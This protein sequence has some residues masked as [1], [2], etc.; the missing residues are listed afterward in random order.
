MF[1]FTIYRV[2]QKGNIKIQI[3]LLAKKKL[4]QSNGEIIHESVAENKIE[5]GWE[6]RK[7]KQDKSEVPPIHIS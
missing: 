4:K 6:I 2:K 1:R 5:F 7:L 3:K